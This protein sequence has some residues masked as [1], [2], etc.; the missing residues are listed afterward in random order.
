[1]KPIEAIYLIT[2]ESGLSLSNIST[3]MG[4]SRQFVATIIGRNCCPVTKTLIEILDVCDYALCAIP[5]GKVPEN[6]VVIDLNDSDD[7]R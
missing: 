7:G 5:K 4:K 2:N 6:A 1:M 3:A